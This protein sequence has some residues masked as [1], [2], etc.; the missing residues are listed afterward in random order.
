MKGKC[1]LHDIL[2]SLLDCFE[3]KRRWGGGRGPG[4]DIGTD[5][6]REKAKYIGRHRDREE[7]YRN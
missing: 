4:G 2:K 6:E 7:R 5:K 1:F 3:E